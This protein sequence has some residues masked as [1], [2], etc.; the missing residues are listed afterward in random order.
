MNI[1]TNFLICCFFEGLFLFLIA[2]FK[3]FP[4]VFAFQILSQCACIW[5]TVYLSYF[6]FLELPIMSTN[7]F[8]WFCSIC[9][10]CSFRCFFYSILFLPWF[11]IF[12]TFSRKPSCLSCSF[13][14]LQSFFSPYFSKCIFFGLIFHCTNPVLF[15]AFSLPVN[16]TT[17]FL[18]LILYPQLWN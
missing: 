13:F 12:K 9:S 14:T 6:R 4:L 18:V 16:S 10:H 11:H 17:E 1:C 7:I 3:K 8:H 15:S 5:L 2:A